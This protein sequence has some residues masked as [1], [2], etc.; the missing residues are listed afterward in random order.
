[1]SLE[2]SEDLPKIR[3]TKFYLPKNRIYLFDVNQNISIYKLKKMII[4]AAN[5]GKNV[6]LFHEGIEYTDKDSY[7]LDELF[8]ELQLVEFKI[9]L[10]D[11]EI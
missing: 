1:M 10:P 11:L 8:P 4:V 3:Q 7:C 5:L 2:L 9:E 6:R